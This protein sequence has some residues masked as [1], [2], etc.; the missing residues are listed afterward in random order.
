M[1]SASKLLL[2]AK[3]FAARENFSGVTFVGKGAFKETFK[4]TRENG[5]VIALKLSEKAKSNPFRTEREIKALLTCNSPLICKLYNSGMFSSNN[6]KEFYFSIEEFLDGGTLTDKINTSV[7]HPKFVREYGISLVKA[8]EILKNNNFV[9]RDIKPDN[10]MFRANISE[11]VL[12]DFGLVRDLSESSLT[13]TWS[14][15]GPGTPYYSAPEQLNNDKHLI[16]WRTDQFCLGIVLGICLT[17]QHPFQEK[18]MTAQETVEAVA[19]RKTCTNDFVQKVKAL[20]FDGFIKML[21]PWPIH[22][23]SS[24]KDLLQFF[25]SVK[26]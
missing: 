1:S 6:G 16:K 15:T 10:I 12:V 22:R 19:Q 18:T 2:V 9:H 17:G 13:K 14:P 23:Y 26:I 4:T 11:P 21:A 25:E 5:E 7:I 20:G 3:E 24:I 8:L